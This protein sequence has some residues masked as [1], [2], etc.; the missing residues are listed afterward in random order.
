MFEQEYYSQA[1]FLALMKVMGG[2]ELVPGI[3]FRVS[4]ATDSE[5]HEPEYYEYVNG[6]R[7]AKWGAMAGVL[8]WR[9]LRAY[10]KGTSGI[11][12]NIKRG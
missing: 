7:I 8:R 6:I 11:E 2:E 12:R 10:Y 4:T 3:L 1:E 9:H 5:Y